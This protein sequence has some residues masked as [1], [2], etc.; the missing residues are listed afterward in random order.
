MD[1]RNF[2]VAI[3]VLLT[4]TS[5]AVAAQFDLVTD[6]AMLVVL[7]IGIATMGISANKQRTTTD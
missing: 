4:I 6:S 5:G 7:A 3:F 1:R 2:G